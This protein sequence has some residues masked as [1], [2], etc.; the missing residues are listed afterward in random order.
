MVEPRE[1]KEQV[2]ATTKQREKEMK[3]Y[4]ADE[5]IGV[6]NR[7]GVDEAWLRSIGRVN[8]LFL[9]CNIYQVTNNNTNS[10]HSR[11]KPTQK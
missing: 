1:E 10:S 6:N 7:S 3:K 5:S 9:L 4:V 8:T 11:T 2:I